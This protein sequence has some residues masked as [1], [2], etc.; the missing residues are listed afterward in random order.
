MSDITYA[1]QPGE[2][3]VFCTGTGYWV[4]R[5]SNAPRMIGG[6]VPKELP[7]ITSATENVLALFTR[8]PAGKVIPS[9]DNTTLFY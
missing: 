5:L 8:G 3:G 9:V 1:A 7:G 6:W 2:G 4:Y